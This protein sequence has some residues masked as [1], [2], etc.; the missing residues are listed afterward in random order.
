MEKKKINIS[1][2]IPEMPE[3]FDETAERTLMRVCRNTQKEESG[4]ARTWAAESN[5]QRKRKTQVLAKRIGAVAAVILVVCTLTAGGFAALHALNSRTEPA[6]PDTI[7]S[8]EPQIRTVHVS[9]VDAF[10]A[11]I[12]SDTEIVMENGVY[13]L[14]EAKDY[15]ENRKDTAYIWS[16]VEDGYELVL[17]GISN[18][19]IVG[20]GD[21]TVCTDPR[22]ASVF[23][24]QSCDGVEV[25]NLTAG[26]TEKTEKCSGEVLRLDR[27][28]NTRIENCALYGC[29]TWGVTGWECDTI[30][31]RGTDIYECSM[32]AVHLFA[33]TDVMLTESTVRSCG[34]YA[35]ALANLI[36]AED[37]E[38]AITDCDIYGNRTGDAALIHT[39]GDGTYTVSVIGTSIRDND[40]PRNRSVFDYVTGET[41]R[42][43]VDGCEFRDNGAHILSGGQKVF[44]IDGNQIGETELEAMQ[45]NRTSDEPPVTPDTPDTPDASLSETFRFWSY[46]EENGY[47]EAPKEGVMF[48]CDFDGD[49][50][51]E[52]ITYRLN[53]SNIEITVGGASD[54]LVIGAEISHAILIDLDPDAAG[55]NLLVVCNFGSED[56]ETMELYLKN[57]KLKKGPTINV[58]CEWD[59]TAL[60]GSRSQTDILGTRFGVRTYHGADLTPDSEWFDSEHIPTESE[61]VSE[62]EMLEETGILLHV[63]RDLPC[64]I[65]GHDAVIEKGAYL[66]VT[67]WH[68]SHTLVEVQTEDGRTAQISVEWQDEI[69]Y[70]IAGLHQN[71]YFDSVFY[72]D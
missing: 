25:F 68:E 23:N 5:K 38:L 16:E 43:I 67:R 55:L 47:Q 72:A 4:S 60:R 62:R 35:A 28:K 54:S 50:T 41:Y 31:V 1:D 34:S 42:L 29:G 21:T 49:G 8:S 44:D 63:K 2:A 15:G 48:V 6:A 14:S 13:N 58:Y 37:T 57:G 22:D 71:E 40:L 3:S 36:Y 24:I 17:S 18:L 11:A 64:T 45:L 39:G 46:D 56:Y 66:Y 30:D 27:N 32:G 69:G 9:D 52:E 10:L 33:C 19:H 53:D 70:T 12:A 65:D 51:E 7:A 59:G 26:H 20:S 61:L